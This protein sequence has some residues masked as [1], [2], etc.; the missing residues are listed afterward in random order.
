MPLN[1]QTLNIPYRPSL[2][3]QNAFASSRG[4]RG[5][6]PGGY[7]FPRSSTHTDLPASASR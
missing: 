7:G 2:G 6:E 3:S 5:N 4:P 1:D